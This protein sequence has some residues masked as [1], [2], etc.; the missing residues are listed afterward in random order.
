MKRVLVRA[1]LLGV[2]VFAQ[3]TPSFAQTKEG[4]SSGARFDGKWQTTLTCPEKGRTKGYVW[5]VPSLVKDSNFR[6][7]HGTA[8]Q[9]GYLLIVGKIAKNG[10]A[11]L[12]ATGIVASRDYATGVFTGKG[13]DYSYDIKAQFEDAHGTGTKGKG[14]G[15]EGRTCTYEFVK[16]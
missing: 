1:L 4:G 14:L 2:M 16:Q 5:E 7:E 8:G 3:I 12:S 10:T 11:K 9:P 6:G 13:D 15:I